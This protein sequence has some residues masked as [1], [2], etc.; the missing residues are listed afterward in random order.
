ML[1]K[2]PHPLSER[3]TG[4]EIQSFEFPWQRSPDQ[5]AH[6][7]SGAVAHHPLVIVG[8]GPAGL[9]LAIDLAQRGQRVLLLDNDAR[10]SSGSRAICFA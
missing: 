1:A 2:A 10:L 9:S 4:H 3:S 6:A 5:D 8:A 7:L